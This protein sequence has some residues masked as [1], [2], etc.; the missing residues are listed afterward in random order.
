MS[1][2]KNIDNDNKT[3]NNNNTNNNHSNNKSLEKPAGSHTE[4]IFRIWRSCN[5]NIRTNLDGNKVANLRRDIM[6]KKRL[7]N[8]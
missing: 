4:N 3:D 5:H 7:T 1:T 2:L 6:N 8:F